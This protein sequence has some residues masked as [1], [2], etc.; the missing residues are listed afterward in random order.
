MDEIRQLARAAI[1]RDVDDP[2]AFGDLMRSWIPRI[3]TAP[4]RLFDGGQIV[5]RASFQLNLVALVP[6]AR[7]LQGVVEV[8]SQQLEVDLF[9][10]P[11]ERDRY[12]EQII[13]MKAQNNSLNQTEIACQLGITKTAVQRAFALQRKMDELG[14][15]DPY[16]PVLEPPEDYTKFRR[17]KHKR[18]EFK[19]LNDWAI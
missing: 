4:Y 12:R 17:H 9:D 13:G 7:H 8:L 1:D 16:I 18:Y 11:N 6:E 19:P 14:Q 2:F 5:P 3:V 15:T 10:P